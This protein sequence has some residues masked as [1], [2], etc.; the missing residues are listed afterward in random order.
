MDL[1]KLEN[2][3]RTNLKILKIFGYIIGAIILLALFSILT[4]EETKEELSAVEQAEE[5]SKAIPGANPVNIYLDLEKKG[6]K[7]DKQ[8]SKEYG[9]L[10]SCTLK[11]YA[12][13]YNVQIF[14]NDVTTIES[15]KVTASLTGNEQK[16]TEVLKPFISYIATM[17][18]EGQDVGKVKKWLNENFNNDGASIVIGAAKFTIYGKTPFVRLLTIEKS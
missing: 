7:I 15:V 8:Y 4:S 1:D 12:V 5:L 3:K 18:Y 13:D 11:D 10:W 16:N 9:N 2:R 17:P 14:S 6:Y